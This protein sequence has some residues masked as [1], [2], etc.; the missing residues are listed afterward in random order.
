MDLSSPSTENVHFIIEAIKD[1][2]R[3]VNADAMK[4][5]HFDS[6]NYEDLV[7][8]YELVHKR[9]AFSPSEMQAIVAELGSLRK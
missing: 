8:L 3:M 1:K 6:S 9:D 7:Y 4:P 2:L 5:E